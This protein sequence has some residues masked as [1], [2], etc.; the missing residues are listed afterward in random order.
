MKPTNLALALAVVFTTAAVAL[1]QPPAQV[2][3]PQTPPAAVK[4]APSAPAPAPASAP[5]TAPA[6]AAASPAKT[7][8]DF[9]QAAVQGDSEEIAMGQ[10]MV[11]RGATQQMKAFGRML[12]LDHTQS[13][14]QAQAAAH[15]INVT[16]AE[17]AS[18]DA[19]KAMAGL[20]AKSGPEFDH[21]AKLIAI[22]DHKKDVALFEQEAA[23]GH[24]PAA[25]HAR[26]TLPVLKKHLQAAQ[27]LPG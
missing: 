27:Q 14:Q 6:P 22:E 19:T 11:D 25:D 23:G 7:D 26:T 21:A 4:A 13:R 3:V 10:M 20:H 24:G 16:A 8:S 9:L 5:G 15:L 12:V 17:T 2:N 1:A 18:A